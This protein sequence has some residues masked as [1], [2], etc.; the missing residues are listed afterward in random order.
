MGKLDVSK[1]FAEYNRLKEDG[2]TVVV[3]PERYS[4]LF[5][6]FEMELVS[7]RE[8]KGVE[9]DHI[10]IVDPEAIEAEGISNLY[11]S[12]TR[13]TQ[14]LTIFQEVKVGFPWEAIYAL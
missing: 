5:A 13:A 1:I 9:W 7:A 11:V 10:I 12:L 3:A 2:L 6:G 8:S 4:S 14:S